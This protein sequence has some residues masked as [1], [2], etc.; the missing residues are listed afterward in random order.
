MIITIDGPAGSGKSTVAREVAEALQFHF[1]DTGSMYRAVAWRCLEEGLSEE[2]RLGAIQIARGLKLRCEGDRFYC[3]DRDI[4]ELIRTPEVSRRASVV[5]VI[6]EVR[7]AL[8]QMQQEVGRQHP[9][10]VS[11]GRDQGTVV[12]PEAEHKFFLSATVEERA[13]R[14][15][16]EMQQRGQ[17]ALEWG[18]LLD[19]IRERDERDSLRDIAPLKP[20]P[21]A[22]QIDTTDY[23][24]EAVTG[25]ILESIRGNW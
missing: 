21:D 15:M 5:A 4:T 16:L 18:E 6:P 1:L 3:Q 2:N 23:T 19:Q 17:Q 8:V 14:R 10:I 24:L 25:M 11:E 9:D 13:R 22:R 20:A 12:F 7:Q